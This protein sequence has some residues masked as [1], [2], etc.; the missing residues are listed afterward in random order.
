GD[1]GQIAEQPLN[2]SLTLHV[3]ADAKVYL[4][5]NETKSSG[6]TR[7]FSTTK[8]A[9]GREWQDYA[10]RVE[11]E[12]DGQTLTREETV[13]LKAGEARE[14]TVGFDAPQ[15]AQTAVDRQ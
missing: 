1:E 5:G 4:S 8:L 14:L 3:P 12:R 10:I 13:S 11:I 6:E 2:T 9:N 15:F 7:R